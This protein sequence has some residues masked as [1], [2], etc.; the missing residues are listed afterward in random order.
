MCMQM[1]ASKTA[2]GDEPSAFTACSDHRTR[3]VHDPH[4]AQI[5]VGSAPDGIKSQACDV[6]GI[7]AKAHLRVKTASA[8]IPGFRDSPDRCSAFMQFGRV[9]G[10]G[11]NPVHP[12][13]TARFGFAVGRV[14]RHDD[15][16][17]IGA[18][19]DAARNLESV[20]DRQPS[21]STQRVGTLERTVP[22]PRL[23]A[24][25]HQPETLSIAR[26]V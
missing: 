25:T 2:V 19:P 6:A 9:N 7:L 20:H 4:I 23:R 26:S 17:Q 15:D 16:R 24:R 14:G 11:R 18:L 22:Q 1:P 12:A 8:D 10:L 5:P 13:A 21:T 3:E